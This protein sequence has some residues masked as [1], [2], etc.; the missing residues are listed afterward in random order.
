[1]ILIIIFK[2]LS[3]NISINFLNRE[4]KQELASEL[5]ND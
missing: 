1:M 2:T 5:M 4:E 3:S